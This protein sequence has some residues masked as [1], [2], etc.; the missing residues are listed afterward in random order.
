MSKQNV[1]IYLKGGFFVAITTGG[2][3]KLTNVAIHPKIIHLS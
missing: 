1:G 2:T 3:T